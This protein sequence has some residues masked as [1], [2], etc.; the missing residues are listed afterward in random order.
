MKKEI[1]DDLFTQ[2]YQKI[3]NQ[4]VGK[5][6]KYKTTVNGQTKEDILHNYMLVLLENHE[7]IKIDKSIDQLLNSN[8]EPD[9]KTIDIFCSKVLYKLSRQ[10]QDDNKL[11]Q[12]QKK[13][14]YAVDLENISEEETEDLRVLL[15]ENLYILN[16]EEFMYVTYFNKYK[17]SEAAKKLAIDRKTFRKRMNLTIG[18]IKQHLIVNELIDLQ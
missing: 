14:K 16:D 18:K 2:N 9:K 1:L 4:F 10:F 7:N 6:G 13:M 11:T 15:E 8:S 3:Y 5:K 17:K 12:L